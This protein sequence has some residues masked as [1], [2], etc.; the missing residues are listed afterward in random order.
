[1]EFRVKGTSN[2]NTIEFVKNSIQ[3]SMITYAGKD[4]TGKLVDGSLLID[5]EDCIYNVTL[6]PNPGDGLFQI[7]ISGPQITSGIVRVINASGQVVR[8]L[9]FNDPSELKVLD[10]RGEATGIYLL[11]VDA[12]ERQSTH[13]LIIK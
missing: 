7:R 10:L 1:M 13:Q 2:V 9:S 5:C 6:Y 8:E 4:I 11:Q 12:G 3:N